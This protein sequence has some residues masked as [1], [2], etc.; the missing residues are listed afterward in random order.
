MSDVAPIEEAVSALLDCLVDPLLPS[1]LY[2]KDPPSL[3][4]QQSVSR[5]MHAVG[6]LYNYYYRK[7]DPELCFLEFVPFC[8]LALTLKPT[9]MP[10]MKFTL[11]TDPVGLN[12]LENQLSV[13]E[14]AV[15]DAC[16]ISLS[17][18][19]LKDIPSIEGW[20]ISKVSVLLVDSEKENCVLLFGSVTNG[21][22]SVI[23][24]S[25]DDFNIDL[26]NTSEGKRI[27]QTMT[28]EQLTES[29]FEQL[30]SI[31][32]K[33]ATGIN[34]SDLMVLERH[35]V[36]SLSKEKTAAYFY[37]MQ[38]TSGG[39]IQIPIKDTIES[40]QGPLF[41]WM[42]HSWM[43]TTVVEHYNVLPYAM[44][45]SSWYSRE[46]PS[47]SLQRS[48]VSS[49]PKIE[50]NFGEKFSEREQVTSNGLQNIS[51]EQGNI[52]I[53][54]YLM[55][56]NP[57]YAEVNI[58][59]QCNDGNCNSA[60][61]LVNEK[62][63]TEKSKTMD[64]DAQET[65]QSDKSW[66]ITHPTL[67]QLE[68]LVNEKAVT[69]KSKTMDEDAQETEQS[70]KSWDITHPTLKQLEN[71]V[72]EKAVTEKS[73]MMDEDAQETEQSD[74]SWDITH[75]T[76][77]QL[78][79]LVNEKAVTEK[80]KTMDEDAQ[81]TEQSD[82]SWDITHPTLKQLEN[83]IDANCSGKDTISA[84][85]SKR[86]DK[87][88]Q[89][90]E[91]LDGNCKNAQF[92]GNATVA[93]DKFKMETEEAQ[94]LEQSDKFL[95][96]NHTTVK[97]L[98]NCSGEDTAGTD[99]SK[100][101]ETEVKETG[102]LDA[103][104][105]ISHSTVKESENCV[106]IDCMGEENSGSDNA[107]RVENKVEGPKNS[108]TGK[109]T[110]STV[111]G[112]RDSIGGNSIGKHTIDAYNSKEIKKV[113]KDTEKLDKSLDTMNNEDSEDSKQGPTN[114]L[115]I[116]CFLP[117]K[118][119]QTDDG[120]V[121]MRFTKNGDKN[122]S[123]DSPMRVY[124]HQKRKIPVK[125]GACASVGGGVNV[126]SAGSPKSNRFNSREGKDSGTGINWTLPYNLNW[127][128]GE[129]Y[130]PV[131]LEPNARSV[132]TQQATLVTKDVAL[133]QT[134]LGH[135]F[136]KRAKMCHQARL[137]HDEIAACDQNI[138]K[139]LEG[140]EDALALMLDA[141]MDGCNDACFKDKYQHESYQHG[142]HR[143]LNQL[144]TTKRISDAIF[145]LRSPTQ[146]L[147]GICGVNG[148]MVNYSVSAPD[149]NCFLLLK[150]LQI[151]LL[152]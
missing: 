105:D 146:D 58:E 141:I 46:F 137:M 93:T 103:L 81:E 15:M 82:K 8:K 63:V 37:I 107:K 65:E 34:H 108:D 72:N 87:E 32:V 143:R 66:D 22:W 7:Q 25:V 118:R 89:E 53:N 17:L 50:E 135:L 109:L 149:V 117:R 16:N 99:N 27:S 20:P 80:S 9:L 92:R 151:Q 102:S 1:K 75:P 28:G 148:W 142:G 5:Q 6:L 19:A 144:R 83:C 18:D 112:L 42:S 51:V 126:E 88:V 125:S 40:L 64:E 98:E 31:A 150:K 116:S 61:H 68:N 111:E 21:V 101:A 10:H 113:I 132:E 127:T 3:D 131:C 26:E 128:Q 71:L 43:T 138:Q 91:K 47:I 57:C 33:E 100:R 86:A 124:H 13:T 45:L 97:E 119:Q 129:D 12:D 70:D 90:A 60:K 84:E 122:K 41:E 56:E 38:C 85:N 24:K 114:E 77:K 30:A 69:E 59:G 36:Y 74:K 2:G 96:I 35:V 134:A 136:S 54:S 48:N 14:K 120:G 23:E 49:I 62:A 4:N 73:K 76:L 94:E 139:I 123:A 11:Q 67:K 29:Y 130:A 52:E 79:N 44:I 78:E 147:N 39:D 110:H 104:S 55:L 106:R 133:A 121:I 152:H 115:Q 145:N 140:N 95:D